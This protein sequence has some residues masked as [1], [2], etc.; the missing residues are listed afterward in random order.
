M[1]VSGQIQAM[2]HRMLKPYRKMNKTS[3]VSSTPCGAGGQTVTRAV[4]PW[5]RCCV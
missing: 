1:T 2:G 3:K 4:V 5:C